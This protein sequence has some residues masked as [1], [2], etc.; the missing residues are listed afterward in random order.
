MGYFYLN[1]IACEK[2]IKEAIKYFEI[3]SKNNYSESYL[4]LAKIY[5][6]GIEGIEKNLEESYKL[7]EKSADLNNPVACYYVG[8]F[9]A[10]GIGFKKDLNK[11]FYYYDKSSSGDIEIGRYYLVKF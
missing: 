1:G 7:Y 10:K 8:Y 11:A 6:N 2:N 9:Y 3:S 5:Y 4:E